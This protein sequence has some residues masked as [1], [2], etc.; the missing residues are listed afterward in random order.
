MA[1]AAA[2]TLAFIEAH[3]VDA[4]RVLETLPAPE[5]S[6]LFARVPPRLGAPVLAAMLPPTAARNVLALDDERGMALLAALGA[7]AAVAVLRHVPE[8]R[9]SALIDGLPTVSAVAS[10]MLLGYPEDS[11]GAWTDTDIVAL[12]PEARAADALARVRAAR[13]DASVVHV[14][15]PGERLLGLVDLA[16]LVRAP[17]TAD[18]GQLMRRPEA[19]LA[20]VAP[21][22]G[23]AS[24]RGWLRSS[25]LPVVERGD[26]LVGVLRRGTLARALARGGG[27]A[28]VV[29]SAGLAETLGRGY[30]DALSGIISAAVTLLPPAQRIKEDSDEH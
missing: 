12:P 2:L 1:D 7:Q 4:A 29:V 25:V 21:L 22:G 26:R 15:G 28:S 8:P 30:W 24:H 6:A 9:R 13:D 5:S 27:R 23:A 14:V 10:R 3:P 16:T 20:A 11:V 19:V 18:M 17:E